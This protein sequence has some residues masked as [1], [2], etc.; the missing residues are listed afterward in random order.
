MPFPNYSYPFMGNYSPAQPFVSQAPVYTYTPQA[1]NVAPA[2]SQA[3]QKGF[4]CVPVT[5][6]AEAVAYQIPFDGSTTYFADTSNGCIYAKTFNFQNGT[7]PLE[8]Y[9]KETETAA[10]SVQYVTVEMFE[11]L[12]REVTELKKPRKVVKKYEPVDDDDE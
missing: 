10:T 3:Q 1:Q 11:E 9:V 8:V 5:S 2:A 4:L 12:K 6:K 7:A